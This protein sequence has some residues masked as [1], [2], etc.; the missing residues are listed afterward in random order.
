MV[1]DENVEKCRTKATYS[2]C[3][4]L[5]LSIPLASFTESR[6]RLLLSLYWSYG[7]GAICEEMEMHNE[8]VS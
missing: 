6:S 3:I 7:L 4:N 1:N 8:E 5:A 2:E